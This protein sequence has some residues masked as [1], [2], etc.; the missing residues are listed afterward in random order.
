MDDYMSNEFLIC[1]WQIINKLVEEVDDVIY[2]VVS[3]YRLL[4]V[5]KHLYYQ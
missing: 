1:Q 4:S 5:N 2:H 3:N